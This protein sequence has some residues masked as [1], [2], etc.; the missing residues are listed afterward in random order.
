MFRTIVE[1]QPSPCKITYQ[2]QIITL[3]SCFSENIG[4]KLQNAF[5]L[6]D[7]NPFGVL[8]NP[9]SI[10]NS[11]QMLL[12]N[13]RFCEN[14]LF[15]DRSLWNSYAHSTMFSAPTVDETLHKINSRIETAIKSLKNASFLLITF[16]TAW[17]FE[18]KETKE[19]VSNCHKQPSDKFQ[20]Y[21]LKVDDIIGDYIALIH[22]LNILYPDLKIIFTVSPIRHW[23]DGAHENNVSKATLLL[24]IDK[25]CAC[26]PFVYYFPAYEIMMDELRDY[27]FYAD[28]MFH[29]SEMAV[30]YIWQRFIETYFSSE[31]RKLI[32]RLEQ[33]QKDLQHRPIHPDSIENSFF[34]YKIQDKKTN[35]KKEFPFLSDRF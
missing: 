31:N 7:I 35:L 11:I 5:L 21:R 17:V 32:T 9:V 10:K 2:D 28:D 15:F 30:N 34:N 8:F 25:L 12:E 16:G 26:F 13:K 23:K 1:I 33:L 6:T 4:N 24:A 3:G 14:D 29:P 18:N 22:K 27:R 20:R 19:I